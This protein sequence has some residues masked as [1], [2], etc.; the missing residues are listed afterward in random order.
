[1]QPFK[2]AGLLTAFAPEEARDV[3]VSVASQVWRFRRE[4][5]WQAVDPPRAVPA[6]VTARLDGALRLLRDAAPLRTLTAEEV[7]R[8]SGAE[9]A[10]G[11][12]S[13]AVR[14]RTSTGATFQVQ[15]GGR[16]PLGSARYAR[17]DGMEGV[18]MLPAY[19]AEAWEKVIEEPPR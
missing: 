15:F 3:E 14:V 16:N 12:D 10:L 9:Y 17:I 18:P 5:G 4:S 6:D 7:A 11:P 13:L 1:M 2:R 8:V 19:V